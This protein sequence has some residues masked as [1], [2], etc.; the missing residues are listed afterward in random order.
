MESTEGAGFDRR[1][2]IGLVEERVRERLS[3]ESTGHDWWHIDRVRRTAMSI[4]EVT[5]NA[6]TYAVELAALLHDV[7]DWK[8]NGGD[9]EASSRTAEEW[10]NELGVDAATIALVSSAISDVTFKGVG[11]ARAPATVEGKIVQD[12]DRLDAIGA[13]GIGRAFAYGGRMGR[14]MHSPGEIPRQ[15][16]TFEEY[17]RSRSST[18]NHFHE[19]LLHLRDLMNTAR[20]REI[21]EGRHMFML[22]FLDRFGLEW[23]G[24]DCPGVNGGG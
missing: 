13:I 22:E 23:E 17:R 6:D 12:A 2:T 20:G 8:F 7:S 5:G 9:E 19:K 24:R 14:E 21:A 11:Q 4:A 16:A 10:L 1:R 18:I 15:H 3:G